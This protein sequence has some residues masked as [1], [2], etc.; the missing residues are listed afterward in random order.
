MTIKPSIRRGAMAASLLLL[1]AVLTV[2]CSHKKKSP[3]AQQG[4][5]YSTVSTPEFCADSAYRYVEEQ[6]AFG[7][8][9]PESKGQKECAAYLKNKMRQWCDTVITQPFS[10]VLW[11]GQTVR[12]ENIIASLNPEKSDRIMLCAHW[13]SRLWADHDPD[14][15]NHRKP[16][17][18]A[19]DGASG[20]AT[21]ME[22]ARVMSDMRPS[23]GVDFIFFDV[24]DQG[25]PE[26]SDVP[27]EDNTWCK[28]SQY[29]ANNPHR[30]YYSAIYGILLDMVGTSAPR[31]TKE[32]ISRRYA[33]SLMDKMWKAAA[34]I[35]YSSVFV[36]LKSD[37][38]L[39]DH[40]Y[41]NQ[42]ANIPT[43]DIVQN[44][45]DCSFFP[46][47]HTVDDN[48]EAIERR[49]MKTVADVV[50]KTIY[51]DYGN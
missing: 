42:I 36:D 7:F 32:E 15:A 23:V 19:N 31:F 48:I 5:D 3:A 12:G 25:I 39:D 6:L 22:M 30:P 14:S 43:I 49:S 21:L 51:G 38:I 16:I 35:G 47:W 28:G 34:A 45:P 18:G 17:M 9:T 37:A 11:N 27:Y 40:L 33:P 46:L 10:T 29:W 4:V 26:W 20:V 13:D 2:S 41:V 24:E 1:A 44:D 50:M 8:R